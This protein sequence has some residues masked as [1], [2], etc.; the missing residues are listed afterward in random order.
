M[1]YEKGLGGIYLG[2]FKELDTNI[3][4]LGFG[5]MRFPTLED[6]KIDREKSTAMLDHAYNS[7][8]KYYDTAWA[9]HEEESQYFIGEYLSKHPRDSF[10]LATKMPVWLLESHDD[11]E[12]FFSQQ[13]ERCQVEYFDYYLMHAINTH[14]LANAE[15]YDTYEFLK[16]K[17]EEGIIKHLGFSFH[18]DLNTLEY[19]LDTY[20]WDFVQ[21]QL[22]YFDF[23]YPASNAK[24]EYEMVTKAGLPIVIMEPV[25]GGF[26]ADLPRGAGEL[27]K[28]EL[29]DQS[30]AS[31]AMRWCMS[32]ENVPMIL[33]GMSSMEQVED[34]LST[35]DKGEVLTE[36]EN[37]LIHTVTQQLLEC[38]T[39]P[40]TACRY[41]M[42]CE[43][44]VSIPDMFRLYNSYQLTGDKE[45]ARKSYS[46]L[47][48]H[49]ATADYCTHCMECVPKCPQNI[50][51]PEEF[52][53]IKPILDSI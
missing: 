4:R 23:S 12:Y 22:N 13:L 16:K 28:K 11:L 48:E 10:S 19:M 47:K 18:G 26:L 36:K 45:K 41:C 14:Y 39:V 42:D 50:I 43:F 9:Y 40:C 37:A 35:F 38:D 25:R 29:P 53:R 20:E 46:E 6:G 51:I 33:S 21:L 34:N 44:G 32:L 24:T 52:D 2:I 49:S 30:I 5:T 7:G 17:K 27:L 3:S 15:K 31:W 8:I 1:R